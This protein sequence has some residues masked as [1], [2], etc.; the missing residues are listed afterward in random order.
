MRDRRRVEVGEQPVGRRPRL[1]AGLARDHV[2][3]DPEAQR[4]GASAAGVTAAA[5]R[6]RTRVELVRH[7]LRRLAPRQVDVGVARGDVE[8]RRRRAAEV[9]PRE[10]GRVG[11]LRALGPDEAPVVSRRAT[12]STRPGPRR[13]TRRRA[14]SGRPWGRSRRSASA[15]PR[16]RRRPR[17]AAAARCD[18]RW[19]VAAICA[20]SVGDSSPGRKATRNFSRCVTCVSAAVAIHA[21]SHHVPVGVSAPSKPSCSAERAICPRYS[22]LGGRSPAA[23]SARR[24]WAPT[25]LP[26]PRIVAGVAGGGQEPMQGDGHARLLRL[27]GARPVVTIDGE[28][29][30]LRDDLVLGQRVGQRLLELRRLRRDGRERRQ[31][32]GH[33]GAGGRLR[34]AGLLRP[35]VG[36]LVLVRPAP[37]RTPAAGARCSP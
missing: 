10:R 12:A 28:V 19:N 33:R 3:A 21:S 11:D 37:R 18:T 1:V 8:R 17:S 13:G 27:P 4:P 20:A 32:L 6:S 5:S 14:R 34:Q 16:R 22:A 31:A 26:A 30:L 15:R 24:W 35:R 23:A 29:D 7:R 9:D 36:P 25:A 2:Q